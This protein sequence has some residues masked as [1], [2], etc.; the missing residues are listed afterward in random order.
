MSHFK[1]LGLKHFVDGCREA[2]VAGFKRLQMRK[3]NSPSVHRNG[4]PQSGLLRRLMS[5]SFPKAKPP[6]CVRTATPKLPPGK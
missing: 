5:G 3:P 6:R 2:S 4:V 1:R